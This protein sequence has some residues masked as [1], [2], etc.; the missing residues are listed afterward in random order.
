[1]SAPAASPAQSEQLL[2]EFAIRRVAES[3]AYAVDSGDGALFA[4]QFTPDGLLISPRGSFQGAELQGVP[5]MMQR[6][7]LRT[8]HAVVGHL[9]Q[10]SPDRQ[11]ATAET[12]CYARHY[13]RR[14]G[15]DYCYEMTIRYHDLLRRLPEGWRIAERRLELIGE[16]GWQAAARPEP[17]EYGGRDAR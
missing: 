12:A 13:L 6:A 3:Y 14:D 15:G 16:A 4:A 5:A 10:L 1:M 7:Y 17:S 8:H 11:S 2:A 9:A